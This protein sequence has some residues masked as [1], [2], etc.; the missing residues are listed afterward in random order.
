[1]FL[2]PVDKVMEE[3]M[4]QSQS[5]THIGSEWFTDLDYAD[6]VALWL[7]ESCGNGNAPERSTPQMMM[8]VEA[9]QSLQGNVY[10]IHSAQLHLEHC[11]V[12]VIQCS[13]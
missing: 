11:Q 13:C 5:S 4:E 10:C 9:I 1:M 6:D 2:H 12:S 8:M 3:T 7:T